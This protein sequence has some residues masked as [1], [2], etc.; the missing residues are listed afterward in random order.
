[1]LRPSR[2]AEVAKIQYG[3]WA[4][5]QSDEHN[6]A[7]LFDWE[8]Q[9][10]AKWFPASGPLLLGAC[11]GG[12][13][14]LALAGKS[15]QMTGF[16]CQPSLVSYAQSLL[17]REGVEAEILLTDPDEVPRFDRSFQAAILG[18]GAYIHIIG[19]DRR[20]RILRKMADQLEPDAPILIS[21]FV[22]HEASKR[23]KWIYWVAK[24][25]SLL[26]FNRRKV[27]LGDTLEGTFDHYF[28]EEEV[29]DELS[30][31]GLSVV[32]YAAKPFGHAVG[33]KQQGR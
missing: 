23:I 28:T 5:Y 14:L 29:R 33:I 19:R 17:S 9:A 4:R 22:R 32:H 25:V 12:R 26:T 20:I 10:I 11:G 1:M 16:E 13:E 6:K 3:Q 30:A 18:W 27:E 15:Y 21:F 2:F 8:E 24:A 31:A 7:G